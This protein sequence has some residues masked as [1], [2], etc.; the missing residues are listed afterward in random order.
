[1]SQQ[2][3]IFQVR[4]LYRQGKK[5]MNHLTIECVKNTICRYAKAGNPGIDWAL[6]SRI[7]EEAM[8]QVF[9]IEKVW[10]RRRVKFVLAYLR[11]EGFWVSRSGNDIRIGWM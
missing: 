1:M 4:D 3:L 10:R 7:V 8:Q 9:P 2:D 6:L 11:K 5:T